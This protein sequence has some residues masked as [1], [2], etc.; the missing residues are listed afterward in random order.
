[1]SSPNETERRDSRYRED[2]ENALFGHFSCFGS[3]RVLFV[4]G[5]EHVAVM[6]ADS[7]VAAGKRSAC[8]A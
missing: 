1:M 3:K 7:G 6:S 2:A 4:E 8:P 5:D